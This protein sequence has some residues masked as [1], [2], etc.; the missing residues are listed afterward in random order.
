MRIPLSRAAALLALTAAC[1]RAGGWADGLRRCQSGLRDQESPAALS[2]G[3]VD[4]SSGRSRTASAPLELVERSREELGATGGEA[5]EFGR[6]R[7]KSNIYRASLDGELDSVA[8]LEEIEEKGQRMAQAQ[9]AIELGRQLMEEAA[10]AFGVGSPAALIAL[11][12]RVA[13][14]ELTRVL[15][16]EGLRREYSFALEGARLALMIEA[17]RAITEAGDGLSIEID[18]RDSWRYLMDLQGLPLIL[19]HVRDHA[20]TRR[21]EG[22]ASAED[23]RRFQTLLEAYA[24]GEP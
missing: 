21:R 11:G 22:P 4:P 24:A 6:T 16:D 12:D 7:R 3:L 18:S 5:S 10:Q 17:R 15:E 8:F 14:R 20:E 13:G 2:C 19:Y 23:R 9:A 1:A